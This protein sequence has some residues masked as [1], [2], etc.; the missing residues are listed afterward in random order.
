MKWQIRQEPGVANPMLVWFKVYA[1]IDGQ[2]KHCDVFTN[3]ADARAF[4][5]KY[6][7]GPVVSRVVAEIV[8]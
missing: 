3:E 6:P 2:W 7:S 5:A 4:I 8:T 1:E